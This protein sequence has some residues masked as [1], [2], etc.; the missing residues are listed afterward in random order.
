MTLATGKGGRYRYYKC[1]TRIGKGIDYCESE[2][3]PMQKLDALVLHSLA[4][5]VFTAARVRLMLEALARQ[6]KDSGKQQQ[7]Q[8]ETLNRELAA[9]TR[10]ME[11]RYEG[12]EQGVLKLDDTLRQRT[13]KLQAQRQAILTDI[14]QLKTKTTVPAHVLQKKHIDPFTRLVRAKLLENGAFAKEYLRLLVSEIRVNKRE[15]QIT[16]SYAALA[17]AVAGNP[18]DVMGVP[19]FVPKW[20]A[21]PARSTQ[22]DQYAFHS[23]RQRGARRRTGR[24]GCGSAGHRPQSRP[25]PCG[26]LRELPRDQRRERRRCRAARREA[27][28]RDR[29]Q[30]AG[31]Q[32]GC[33]AGDDHAPAREGLHRRADRAS[34][35]LVRGAEGEVRETT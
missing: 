1:N 32:D 9:V 17:Q 18:D 19:R 3:L 5:R 16:G 8:L 13:D 24:T 29:P 31:V 27:E 20:L 11:R 14:A 4:D 2:N 33:E 30:D 26:Y 6:A 21:I 12:V 23:V 7:R 25:E 34:G 22:G 35:R 15:V 28:G 10:G